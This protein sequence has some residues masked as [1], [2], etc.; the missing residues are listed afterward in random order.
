MD[1]NSQ[2]IILDVKGLKKYFPLRTGGIFAKTT[3]YIKAVDDV[4]F[5]VRRGETIGVVGESG[6]GKTTLGRTISKL[7]NATDGEMSVYLEDGSV[8]DVN[9]MD[10]EATK[11]FRR[12]VQM[13]FQDPYASLNPRM[14]VL[15]IVGEALLVNDVAKGEDLERRVAEIVK[16]VGLK[17]EHLRRYPHSFSGGQRQRIGIARALVINPQLVVADEPV[18]ALDVSIQAQILNQLKDLAR[19]F[20]LSYIFVSHNMSVIRYMSDRIM[21]MYAGKLVEIA[22]KQVLLNQP[23][24]PYSEMLLSA[25]PRVSRRGTYRIVT[26]GEPPDLLNLPKGCVFNPRCKYAEGPCFEENPKLIQVG[27]DHFV[28]CHHYDKFKLNGV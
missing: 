4:S 17:V 23:R 8:L 20:G 9:T 1:K 18:S 12:N 28:R 7:Y 10:K 6:C 15:N 26:P 3:G 5:Y 24:H 11:K 22:P 16:H 25:V 21:V 13:I 14:T 2:D 27:E 19:D